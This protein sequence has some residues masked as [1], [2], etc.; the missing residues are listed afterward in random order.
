M[1]KIVELGAEGFLSYG[2]IVLRLEEGLTQLLGGN[3]VGKTN[4]ITLLTEALFSK[5]PRGYSKGELINRSGKYKSATIYVKFIGNDK[6][7]YV[8]K[9]VRNKTTA[10][11]TLTKDGEDVS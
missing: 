10:K 5:N 3:G 9:T 8:A 11:V 7:E 6:S 1:A 4:L 2:K